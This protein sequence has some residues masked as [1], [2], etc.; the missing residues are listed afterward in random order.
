MVFST[1]P[2]N[3]NVSIY[4]IKVAGPLMVQIQFIRRP[5]NF[6]KKIRKMRMEEGRIVKSP[7]D[8]RFP[9]FLDVMSDP[10]THGSGRFRAFRQDVN[11]RT[12]KRG[13]Y[14]KWENL[15]GWRWVLISHNLLIIS[16][17]CWRWFFNF[18]EFSIER[19][20][21]RRERV[22]DG[23]GDKNSYFA[24]VSI[25][26][27]IYIY[28]WSI[29]WKYWKENAHF[30]VPLKGLILSHERSHTTYWCL[31]VCVRCWKFYGIIYYISL[32]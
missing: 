20:G 31:C 30:S 1:L 2:P 8:F 25:M 28:I 27:S 7:F 21:F 16:H 24:F 17:Y 4:E 22:A 3:L 5:P 9:M 19:L 26:G 11:K 18:G 13:A 32:K 15:Q 6:P 29:F 12:T 23:K 14:L 10:F